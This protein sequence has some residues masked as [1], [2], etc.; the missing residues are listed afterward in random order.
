MAHDGTQG[1]LDEQSVS[2]IEYE[3]HKFVGSRWNVEI[4]PPNV[5]EGID[6]PGFFL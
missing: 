6:F 1:W 5:V 4:G 3:I 2:D